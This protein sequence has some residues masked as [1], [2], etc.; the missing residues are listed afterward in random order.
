M[1]TMEIITS[2]FTPATTSFTIFMIVGYFLSNVLNANSRIKIWTYSIIF[3]IVMLTIFV[4]I[5]GEGN[6]YKYGQI[7]GQCLISTIATIILMIVRL[8]GKLKKE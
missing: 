8:N 1:T 3:P 6:A 5:M 2:F 7:T 4:I